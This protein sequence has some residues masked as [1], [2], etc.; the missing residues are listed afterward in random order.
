MIEKFNVGDKIAKYSAIINGTGIT[1]TEYEVVDVLPEGTYACK[2]KYTGDIINLKNFDPEP[3]RQRHKDDKYAWQ[4]TWIQ[5]R[6]FDGR[7]VSLD[8]VD[9]KDIKAGDVVIEGNHLSLGWYRVLTQVDGKHWEYFE[10]GC[11]HSTSPEFC[12]WKV[13]GQK[14]SNGRLVEIRYKENEVD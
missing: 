14:S 13:E 1:M 6:E 2:E 10:D 9:W 4:D 3:E 11:Y 8:E 12:H 7:P 5:L